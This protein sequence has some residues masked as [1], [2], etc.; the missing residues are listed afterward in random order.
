MHYYMFTAGKLLEILKNSAILCPKWNLKYFLE[1]Q[2]QLRFCCQPVKNSIFGISTPSYNFWSAIL[3]II[4][5]W[6][7]ENS[8]RFC[9]SLFHHLRLTW[10]WSMTQWSDS[11]LISAYFNLMKVMIFRNLVSGLN[12]WYGINP[13]G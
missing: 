10:A 12:Y 7:Q 13:Y 8:Y 3:R 4:I 2:N 9:F 11:E 6:L 5:D 1:A